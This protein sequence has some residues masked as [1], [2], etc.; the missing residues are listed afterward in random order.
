MRPEAGLLV[1]VSVLVLVLV[2]LA[3][4][5]DGVEYGALGGLLAEDGLAGVV[6]LL[7]DLASAVAVLVLVFVLIL[8]LVLV[9]LT[10]LVD[11]VEGCALCSV[12]T[13]DSF[14]GVVKRLGVLAGV[15]GV[16]LPLV[17]VLVLVLPFVL[18]IAFGL[19]GLIDG[20]GRG[21]ERAR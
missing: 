2:V 16:L 11:G 21:S 8:V 5:V 14:T 12:L 6:E 15:V 18:V 7:G 20:P 4:F 3:R 10:G 13:E 19:T 9:V 1:V 17:L